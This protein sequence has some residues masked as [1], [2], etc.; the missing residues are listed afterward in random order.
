RSRGCARCL[1]G[2]GLGLGLRLGFRL[3]RGFGFSG[4]AL[5]LRLLLGSGPI[6]ARRAALWRVVVHVP[7]RAL[8]VEAR[9]GES[10]LQCAAALGA[11]LLRLG[12]ELLNLLEAVAALRA[13]IR[14][15]WQ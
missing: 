15:Q 6:P 2:S 8:E 11:R 4:V 3:R 10:A 5:G 1:L 13:A 12:V 7:T 9:R 14:I